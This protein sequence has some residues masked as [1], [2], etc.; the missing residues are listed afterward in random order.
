MM[1]ESNPNLPHNPNRH[2]THACLSDKPSFLCRQLI[3]AH[4]AAVAAA[5]SARLSLSRLSMDTPSRNINR[6]SRVSSTLSQYFDAEDGNRDGEGERAREVVEP[7]ISEVEE[8]DSPSLSTYD[9]SAALILVHDDSDQE[10]DD[11]PFPFTDSDTEEQRSDQR[12]V[13]FPSPDADFDDDIPSPQFPLRPNSLTLPPLSPSL[14]FLH[15]LTPYL[16]LGALNLPYARLSLK[17][18]L[19][20]LLLSAMAAAFVRQ[21][22]YLLARYLRKASLTEV[23]TDTFARSHGSAHGRRERAKERRRVVI[24]VILRTLVGV[25]GV[26]MAIIYLRRMFFSPFFEDQLLIKEIDAT[27]TLY[28]LLARET[29]PVLSY[30][31]ST[32]LISIPILYLSSARALNYRR[33][34]Y[35]TWLSLVAYLGWL[36]CITYAYSKGVLQPNGGWLGSK[37][38]VP[39]L[40]MLLVQEVWVCLL[41]FILSTATTVFAFCS[42]S[43]LALY[44]SLKS[45]LYS[46]PS[47]TLSSTSR[48]ADKTSFS[49]SFRFLSTASV[50][51]A[52]LLL[53]PSTIFSAFPNSPESVSEMVDVC[54]CQDKC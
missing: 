29:H 15:L 25:L 50:V 37:G 13:E 17:Y 38:I 48:T 21:V 36:C 8:E 12:R 20:A 45:G 18:G 19:P 46:L 26:L 27:Y 43:T 28:P 22:W 47:H 30:V 11:S 40:G 49:R 51:L 52:M 7:N 34:T 9:S 16:R 39:G 10:D 6:H 23:V 24:R 5:T 53:L 14:V 44:A 3:M 2:R 31:L 42:P 33:I 32:S 41:T 4:H 54:S 1:R 35:A